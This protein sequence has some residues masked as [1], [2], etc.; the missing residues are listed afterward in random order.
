VAEEVKYII[1]HCGAEVLIIDPELE[2]IDKLIREV[3]SARHSRP[4]K[5]LS[6]RKELE[7]YIKET[8]QNKREC[9]IDFVKFTEKSEGQCD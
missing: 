2:D 1:E 5:P 3:T 7:A 6:K 4:S 9:P 8:C